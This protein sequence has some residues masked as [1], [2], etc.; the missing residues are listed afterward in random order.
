[1]VFCFSIL[2]LSTDKTQSFSLS[3]VKTSL[4]KP[5]ATKLPLS[6]LTILLHDFLMLNYLQ[7]IHKV[8]SITES[9]SPKQ[10]NVERQYE[11]E[12]QKTLF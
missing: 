11:T 2:N 1:M 3:S 12:D 5:Q 4:A 6:V 8:V 9:V 10:R 7:I